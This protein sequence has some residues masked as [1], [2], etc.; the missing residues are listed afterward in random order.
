MEEEVVVR[1]NNITKNF[2]YVTALNKVSIEVKKNTIFGLLGSNGAGKS[3][4]LHILTGLLNY[5]SGEVYIFGEKI[6][7][8][9]SKILKKRIAIVPQKISLYD[10]LTIYDNLYFFGRAYG[11]KRNQVKERIDYLQNTLKLGNLDRTIRI[12]SGGYQQRVSI[13]VALIADPE[14]IILDE[15]LVGIDIETQKI[16]TDLLLKLKKNK[17]IIMTTHSIRD[18]EKICDNVC[19]LHRGNKLLDGETKSI[20]KEYTPEIGIKLIVVFKD[21]KSAENSLEKLNDKYH[22]DINCNLENE[23]LTINTKKNVYD[24][25]DFLNKD[26]KS[27]RFIENVYI[28]RPNLEDVMFKLIKPE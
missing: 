11:L 6:K 8:K 2:G 21:N 17:T 19:F 25:I 27:R 13:G 22:D 9:Y 5:D 7:N 12:L 16:I 14:L 28:E 26:K 1:V 4:L 15:A 3:T 24:I 20:I 23:T 10:T 18:A